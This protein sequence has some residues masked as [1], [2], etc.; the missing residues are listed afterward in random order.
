MA[1]VEAKLFDKPHDAGENHHL[2]RILVIVATLFVLENILVSGLS[3]SAAKLTASLAAHL[4]YY[5]P[6]GVF[7]LYRP[8]CFGVST[9]I[10]VINY[11]EIQLK[12]Y[13]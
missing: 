12:C 9:M 6:S 4:H 1:Y 5:D 7:A 3:R 2:K 11:Y 10:A 13:Y 8:W